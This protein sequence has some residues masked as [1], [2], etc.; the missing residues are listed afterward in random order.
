MNTTL[1]ISLG[2]LGYAIIGYPLVLA[3]C[4]SLHRTCPGE[5]TSAANP[6]PVNAKQPTMSM[7]LSVYN[8]EAVIARKLKNFQ[9]LAYPRSLLELIVVSDGSTDATDCIV[10]QSSLP[11]VTLLRQ[12][13]RLGK[14][15]ALNL[16][17]RHATGEIL[18]FTDADSML[19]PDCLSKLVRPF[20]DP[21]VGLTSGRSLY[22]DKNGNET[23]GSLYRRYEE[24]IKE[25]EGDLFGIAGADGAVY[26]MRKELFTPLEPAC[27]NDFLHPIQVILAGKKAVAVRDALITEPGTNTDSRTELARQTRIMAQSWF[28]CLH[29]VVP[30]LRAKRWGFLWQLASHK[31]LRWLTLP[32]LLLCAVAAWFTPG[33]FATLTLAGLW[34]FSLCTALGALGQ[35]GIPGRVGWMFMLQSAAAVLGLFQF[36]RG[37][38]YVTWNPRGE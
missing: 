25:K 14:S 17:A 12:E 33:A 18:F 24:W 9:D 11:G 36:I 28:I 8:E 31:L 34:L 38:H 6:P 27:I 1:F 10:N 35:G 13:G 5:T 23:A 2:L 16:A 21:C 19:H 15:S 20:A 22:L 29:Y 37:K 3:F 4:R 26:A 32:L 30:L 7:L